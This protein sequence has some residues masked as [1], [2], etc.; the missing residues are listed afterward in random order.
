MIT[1]LVEFVVRVNSLTN[2]SD[3]HYVFEDECSEEL[4]AQV[5]MFADLNSPEPFRSAMY[6]MGFV[7]Y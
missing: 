5:S 3:A 2:I 7:E 4:R 1:T 6:N